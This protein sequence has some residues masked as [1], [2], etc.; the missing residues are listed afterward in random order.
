MRSR[1]VAVAAF[2]LASA[3]LDLVA[4]ATA[5]SAAACPR[6]PT[7]VKRGSIHTNGIHEV[8]G[9]EWSARRRVLWFEQDSGNPARLYAATRSGRAR[10]NILIPNAHNHDW[11]DMA[12]A[13]NRIYMG[14]IGDNG[15]KRP[16]I[17]IYVLPEPRLTVHRAPARVLNLRYPDGAHNA[18]AMVV[19]PVVGRL[20]IITKERDRDFADVYRVKVTNF[21]SG[22]T[23]RLQRIGRIPIGNVTAAD[24]GPEGLI[25]K[26]YRHGLLYRWA[27]DR[28]VATAIRGRPC[29][30]EIGF[31]ESITFAPGALYAV[32]EGQT[33]PIYRTLRA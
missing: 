23:R 26:N 15:S 5:A 16:D 30:V 8:S 32:P 29:T 6:Y 7:V 17:Q 10:A 11:E 31:G 14:D 12:L 2:L 9:L 19:D 1:F 33:P 3:S 24:L 18:E 4:T 13:G 22:A 20:F 28:R 25:V 27:N 21:R